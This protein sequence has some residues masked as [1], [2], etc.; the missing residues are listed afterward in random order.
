ML[1]RI[2]QL[3]KERDIFLSAPLSLSDCTVTRAYLL[4][5]EGIPK[6]GS[7]V[8]FAIPYHSPEC[9]SYKRNI[10]RY[11]VGQDY[12]L[13]ARQLSCEL[14][15]ILQK[16]F[17][18]NRFALFADHSPIDEREAAA[19][20][21]LGMI[22][23]HGLL[24]TEPYSSY[25]FLAELITD[26]P[27]PSNLKKENTVRYCEGCGACLAVCPYAKGETDTC[28]SSLTQ[29]KGDLTEEEKDT[30]QKYRTAW[31][32]DLCQ[33]ACPHTRSALR[34]GSIDSPITFFRKH[35]LPTPTYNGVMAMTDQQ[36][37]TRAYAW[38]GRSVILRNLAVVKEQDDKEHPQN[39]T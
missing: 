36:F 23:K 3:L 35:L 26:Y 14:L 29:K 24:I 22:G 1:D 31:G 12:H 21:G 28:L 9:E 25:V 16:E 18:E 33:E 13:F 11:A 27:L 10:S 5:R 32:C 8:I 39:Q 2:Q 37:S 17:P 20:G 19:K 6:S 38:R 7:A 15:P 34:K 30:I 4:E